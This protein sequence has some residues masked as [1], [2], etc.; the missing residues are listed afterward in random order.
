ME[1]VTRRFILR[2]FEDGDTAAFE[3]Y[4]NDPR[5]REFYGSEQDNAKHARELIGLFKA[6]AAEQPRLNYQLAIILRDSPQVLVGCCGL[7]CANTEAGTAELGIELAPEYWGRYAYAVEVMQA[8]A[9]FGFDTLEL[10]TIYGGTVSAN[11]RIARL[12]EALGATAVTR[13][14][15][16][17]MSSKGWTQVEWR[18]TRQQW[19]G[20]ARTG[21]ITC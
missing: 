13:T 21:R 2:D 14:A 1:L 12:V 5:S 16:D 15:P 9:M 3:G 7:R 10:H 6:W 11:S 20:R 18:M 8:L 19:I 4:H 17:W